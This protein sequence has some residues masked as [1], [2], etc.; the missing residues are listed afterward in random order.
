MSLLHDSSGVVRL[1]VGPR[2]TNEPNLAVDVAAVGGASNKQ[3]L[4]ASRLADVVERCG[5]AVASKHPL[6][7]VHSNF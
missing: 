7:R 1:M 6:Q 4:T 5:V 3:P 2:A